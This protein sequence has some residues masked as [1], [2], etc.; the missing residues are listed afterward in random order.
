MAGTGDPLALLESK[1]AARARSLSRRPSSMKSNSSGL[2]RQLK[3]FRERFP[4]D[5]RA[6]DYLEKSQPEVM[7]TVL[8]DFKPSREGQTDYSAL[9][10][11]FVRQVRNRVERT[12]RDHRDTDVQESRRARGRD[13]GRERHDREDRGRRRERRRQRR[14][15]RR[16]E[17]CS[18]SASS[19]HTPANDIDCES[20]CSASSSGTHSFLSSSSSSL[21]GGTDEDNVARSAQ[22]NAA[23]AISKAREE[24]AKKLAEIDKQTCRGSMDKL[25]DVEKDLENE[26]QYKLDVYRE[27]LEKEKQAKLDA[28]MTDLERSQSDEVSKLKIAIQKECSSRIADAELELEEKTRKVREQRN[29]KMRSQAARRC[30]RKKEKTDAKEAKKKAHKSARETST[31]LKGP[32]K[33]HRRRKRRRSSGRDTMQERSPGKSRGRRKRDRTMDSRDESRPRSRGGRRDDS[34]EGRD[35]RRRRPNANGDQAALKNLRHK[36]PMDDRAFE[37]LGKVHPEVRREFLRTFKPKR[38]GEDD[39]SALVAT[40]MRC[41]IKRREVSR[42]APQRGGISLRD[43]DDRNRGCGRDGKRDSRDEHSSANFL[44]DFRS[45]YPMDE[46]AFS[47]LGRAA[48]SIQKKVTSEFKPKREGEDDYSALVMAFVRSV[49]GRMG[50]EN[51]QDKSR[52]SRSRSHSRSRR[53]N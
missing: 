44:N 8:D 19:Y 47:I 48:L 20:S 2:D 24:Q 14:V 5:D 32:E 46:K 4:V 3:E 28:A 53:E 6:F 10:T 30:A 22:V 52:R 41:I 45:H 31:E 34:R 40:Y 7:Q 27:E 26:V 39:Y 50:G 11:N 13:G 23:C 36:Y 43:R 17:S 42:G 29:Q 37:N 21:S 16:H 25:A 15:K 35:S 33:G 49:Q 12:R 1:N 38:E 51:E 9:L 18:E